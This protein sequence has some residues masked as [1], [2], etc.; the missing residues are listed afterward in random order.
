[1]ELTKSL[2]E[3]DKIADELLAKSQASDNEVKPEDI[4]ED[5]DAAPTSDEDSKDETTEDEDKDVKKSDVKKSGTD[6]CNCDVKNGDDPDDDDEDDSDEDTVEKNCDPDGDGLA[7]SEDADDEDEDEEDDDEVEPGD[8]TPED[9][10]KSMAETFAADE[11]VAKGID[12]SQFYAAMVDVLSK[13]LG[14]VQYDVQHQGRE[15]SAAVEVIAKSMQA[16]ISA[17]E[18]ARATNDRLTR[19]INKLEKSLERSTE[20]LMDALDEIAAQPVGVRKSVSSI[21]VF[22]RDFDSSINGHPVSGSFDSLS[23][24]EVMNIL[25]QEMYSGNTNVTAQD[26]ISYESGA[27]LRNDL[28]TLVASKCR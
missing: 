9:T 4:S 13:S 27:P 1:M 8:D 6:K 14:E 23:K 26:I 7:K 17:N 25:N 22:D 3:L 24:S 21:D 18:A 10:A 11:I 19:R 28:Q 2:E 12:A 20:K 16:V 15:N 5:T